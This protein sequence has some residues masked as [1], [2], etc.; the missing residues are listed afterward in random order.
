MSAWCHVQA[1]QIVYGPSELPRSYD[2]TSNFD[3]LPEAELRARG[4]LP[5]RFVETAQPGQVITGSTTE[6]TADEVVETQT[7]RDPTPEEIVERERADVPPEVALW[8]FRAAIR[9]AGQFDAVNAAL[10]ANKDTPEGAVAWEV[11]EYGNVIERESALLLSFAATLGFTQ[12]QL[13]DVF[14]VAA[15]IGT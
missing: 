5:H 11:W 12:Q 14:R 10:D 1:G 2:N 8:R 9:Q 6:I 13:D 3:A 7:A 15:G 4:W